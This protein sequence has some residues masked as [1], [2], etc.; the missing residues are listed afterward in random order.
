MNLTPMMR[1]AVA[2]AKDNENRLVRQPGGFWCG[3]AG[4]NGPTYGTSTANA[5][6]CRGVAEWTEWKTGRNGTF[7]IAL[8]LK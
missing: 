6:V 1:A 7:P 4:I 2:T 5:L 8:T 3:K